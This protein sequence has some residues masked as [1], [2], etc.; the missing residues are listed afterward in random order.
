V[1]LSVQIVLKPNYSQPNTA[2]LTLKA[3][4]ESVNISPKIQKEAGIPTQYNSATDH[5]VAV[6]AQE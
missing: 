3:G 2:L 5:Q 6:S 4:T 1:A